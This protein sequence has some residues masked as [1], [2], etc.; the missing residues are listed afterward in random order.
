MKTCPDCRC[1]I[2]TN[3]KRCLRCADPRGPECRECGTWRTTSPDGT[4]SKCRAAARHRTVVR[5]PPPPC[6]SRGPVSGLPTLPFAWLWRGRLVEFSASDAPTL[7]AQAAQH[8][9]EG[10]LDA[11]GLLVLAGLWLEVPERCLCPGIVLAEHR[12][13]P[14]AWLERNAGRLWERAVSQADEPAT[15]GR[16][17]RACASRTG[18]GW[19]WPT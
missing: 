6:R 5:H 11:T 4:C 16:G 15:D 10:T 8:L 2:G 13:T 18:K 1:R 12:D 3:R 9:P 14:A 17:W 7:A 19:A